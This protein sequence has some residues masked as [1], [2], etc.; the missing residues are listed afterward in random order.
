[1]S[2]RLDTLVK[3]R[4]LR[5]DDPF[6]HYGLALEYKSLGR[7][8]EAAITF[9]QMREKFPSYVPQYLMAAQILTSLAR[10]DEARS[11]LTVGIEV[12]R[13]A[14]DA[15]AAGELESALAALP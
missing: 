5:A 7:L 12:A 4:E 10:T 14:R 9:A 1:M 15:H 8:D 2:K 11:V 6:V 3:M 13:K